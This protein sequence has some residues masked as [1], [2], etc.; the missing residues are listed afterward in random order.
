MALFYLAMSVIW[1]LKCLSV[2][3]PDP[4]HKITHFI[5][6][7]RLR[8]GAINPAISCPLFVRLSHRRNLLLPDEFASSA[9]PLTLAQLDFICSARASFFLGERSRILGLVLHLSYI[10]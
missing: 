2:L 7:D 8:C 4:S 6:A 1:S 3:T 10:K 5:D 9:S